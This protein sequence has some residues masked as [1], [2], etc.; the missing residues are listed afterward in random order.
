MDEYT[1]MIKNL[2]LSRDVMTVS[3]KDLICANVM[4]DELIKTLRNPYE[5]IISGN[6]EELI[7]TKINKI[8]MFS[9]RAANNM[10]TLGKYLN[11]KEGEENEDGGECS[12]SRSDSERDNERE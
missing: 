7:Q 3:I 4:M 5:L 1:E 2:E 9:E 10:D 12:S 8:A 6:M 11:N